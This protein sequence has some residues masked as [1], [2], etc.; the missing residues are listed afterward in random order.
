MVYLG[1]FCLA[2]S[3]IGL[4][5]MLV[6]S[7]S[8]GQQH[9]RG[10]FIVRAAR[11]IRIHKDKVKTKIPNNNKTNPQFRLLLESIVFGQTV[12][13]FFLWISTDELKFTVLAINAGLLLLASFGCSILTLLNTW[14]RKKTHILFRI[15]LQAS[16]L[17]IG[18]ILMKFA[19]G[20]ETGLGVFASVKTASYMVMAIYSY[21][22]TV[23]VAIFTMLYVA[24]K[25]SPEKIEEFEF[26]NY[27]LL[28]IMSGLLIGSGLLL[29]YT[30][31]WVNV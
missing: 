20:G 13:W 14:L 18:L 31:R 16:T 15:I 24:L 6:F 27:L 1:A 9:V 10:D 2:V 21:Y 17:I 22:T 4:Y 28:V 8:P 29:I 30:M 19:I 25:G 26:S 7:F 23:V 12:G 3:I 5:I 11:K